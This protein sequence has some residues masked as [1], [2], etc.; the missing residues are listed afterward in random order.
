[1]FANCLRFG[2]A[3]TQ[4]N[5]HGCGDANGGSAANNHVADY[6]GNLLVSLAGHVGFFSGQLRLVDEAYAVVG[7]FESLNH[8]LVIMD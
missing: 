2:T 1:M 3:D 8:G 5:S 7:P 4:G 6:I